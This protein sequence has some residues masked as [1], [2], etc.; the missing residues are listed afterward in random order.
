MIK[1][2]SRVYP[3]PDFGPTIFSTSPWSWFYSETQPYSFLY[4]FQAIFFQILLGLRYCH[5]N[6]VLHRD[7]KC[8]NILVTKSGR[9][10]LGDFG[11]ARICDPLDSRPY[12]NKVITLWYRPP[13]LLIGDERYTSAVDMWSAGCILA[14]LF[15]RKPLF[16]VNEYST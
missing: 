10:K 13:E 14:E 1:S 4:I 11:L 2:L 8:S 5:A 12:T 16:Q 15:Q 3:H 7:L 9:V 6:N